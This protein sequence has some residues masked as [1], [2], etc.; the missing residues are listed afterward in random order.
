M[1]V[2]AGA[3]H[4]QAQLRA[5]ARAAGEDCM[6]HRR[7]QQRRALGACAQQQRLLQRLFDALRDRRRPGLDGGCGGVLA[8]AIV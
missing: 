3:R 6:A 1:R 5:D 4:G 8:A 7:G 2:A